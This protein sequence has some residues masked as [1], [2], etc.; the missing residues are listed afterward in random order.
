MTIQEMKE[1]LKRELSPHRFLHSLGV[2]NTAI[3]L[4]KV[5]GAEPEKAATA[6]ILHDCAKHVDGREA[7]RLCRKYG[8]IIDP[9]TALQPQ[10]LHGPWGHILLKSVWGRG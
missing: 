9:I 8:I 3:E 4:A 5:Y 1:R 6:G 7:F 10:L 2:M